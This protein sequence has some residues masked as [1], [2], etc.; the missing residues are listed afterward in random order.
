MVQMAPYR[1]IANELEKLVKPKIAEG[2]KLL[3]H[4]RRSRELDGIDT[5]ILGRAMDSPPVVIQ[6]IERASR[7]DIT[8]DD[9]NRLSEAVDVQAFELRLPTGHRRCGQD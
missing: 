3:A 9:I 6:D 5:E 7:F 8:L 1:S 2:H 4:V